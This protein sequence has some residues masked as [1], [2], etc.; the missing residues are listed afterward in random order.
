M[1]DP[2]RSNPRPCRSF[3]DSFQAIEEM[4]FVESGTHHEETRTKFFSHGKKTPRAVLWL[5]GYTATTKQFEPLAK[6]CFEL[7]Y[8]AFVPCMPHHGM[9]SDFEAETSKMDAAE[10]AR[11][12]DRV[13]DIACGLGDEVIVGGLSMGGVLTSWVAQQRAEV[14]LA[15]IIAPFLGAK[16]I[17]ARLT[18]M[19]SFIMRIL[20]NR[21]RWWDP[22]THQT[23]KELP[24]NYPC[25]STRSLA[26]IIRLGSKVFDQARKSAPKAGKVWM[27]INDHDQAVNNDLC[28]NLVDVWNRSGAKNV[29]AYHFPDEL[30]LPHDCI[31][32]EQPTGNIKTV[33]QLLLIVIQRYN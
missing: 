4:Q 21:N 30:G 24:F 10:L 33:Y 9:K 19:V 8:N 27:I 32:V 22:Q 11:F 17:P 28:E 6:M 26:N 25:S 31:T 1:P 29:E 5:H 3:E 23:S 13:V 12:A 16:V 15:L 7:G 20:P 14:S 2:F 18:R